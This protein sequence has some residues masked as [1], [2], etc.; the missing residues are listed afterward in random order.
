MSELGS[1]GQG[2]GG[3]Y[4]LLCI[5]MDVKWCVF[6]SFWGHYVFSEGSA[7]DGRKASRRSGNQNVAG[8]YK[9]VFLTV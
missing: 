9:L 3:L 7:S 4:G 8:L 1:Y 6:E 5:E 2:L